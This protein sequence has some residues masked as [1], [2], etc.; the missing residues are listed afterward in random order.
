MNTESNLILC[1]DS[2]E[3]RL[4]RRDGHKCVT[5]VKVRRQFAKI[6]ASRASNATEMIVEAIGRLGGISSADDPLLWPIWPK[7]KPEGMAEIRAAF[8]ACPIV[9]TPLRDP[10][11]LINYDPSHIWPC[12]GATVLVALNTFDLVRAADTYARFSPY[13]PHGRMDES[14]RPQPGK[15]CLLTKDELRLLR[16]DGVED[17]EIVLTYSSDPEKVT[18]HEDTPVPS[19]VRALCAERLGLR[20]VV[21]PALCHPRRGGCFFL[22]LSRGIGYETEARADAECPAALDFCVETNMPPPAPTYR[23]VVWA[24][25][26]DVCHLVRYGGLSIFLGGGRRRKVQL[27]SLGLARAGTVAGAAVYEMDANR[28]TLEAW[29]CKREFT[30]PGKSQRDRN[31]RRV[32]CSKPPSPENTR[33]NIYNTLSPRCFQVTPSDAS[34]E[35]CRK[36][37]EMRVAVTF[38]GGAGVSTLPLKTLG[39]GSTA[40]LNARAVEKGEDE[41]TLDQ[42]RCKIR[43]PRWAAQDTDG[44]LAWLER[45]PNVIMAGMEPSGQVFAVVRVA[46]GTEDQQDEAV[47]RWCDEIGRMFAMQSGSNSWLPESVAVDAAVTIGSLQYTSFKA[48]ALE[49]SC[50]ERY[51]S[52]GE[53][54]EP[55]KMKRSGGAA[56][57]ERAAA[58]VQS[59]PPEFDSEGS[60]NTNLSTA[61]LRIR[62][63]FGRGV[64]AEVMPQLLAKSSLPEKEKRKMARHKLMAT[65]NGKG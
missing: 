35:A 9:P 39:E 56:A 34:R 2:A 63:L 5:A 29:A 38:G 57:S 61:M 46:N 48:A 4:L 53:Y 30:R 37:R 43:A 52:R 33:G 24:G 15:V 8:N 59:L 50:F 10:E 49:T 60:R 42:K 65:T 58:Y 3:A 22:G 28:A 54:S 18:G 62:E 11:N 14:F 27:R 25:G 32:R 36:L 64:L 13:R 7:I 51:K 12:S 17:V 21:A 1:I 23:I 16:I 19:Y 40:Y 55:L 20:V 47:S 45:S 41:I 6:L 26:T 31:L 44:L